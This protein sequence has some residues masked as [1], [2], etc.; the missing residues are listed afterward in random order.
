MGSSGKM[1]G[2]IFHGVE[3][4]P[5]ET[6]SLISH[7]SLYSARD[8]EELRGDDDVAPRVGFLQERNRCQFNFRR[9]GEKSVSV[10]F[11]VN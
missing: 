8:V 4:Q 5:G 3:G 1:C 2:W 9:R 6:E 10:Q 7:I 11:P